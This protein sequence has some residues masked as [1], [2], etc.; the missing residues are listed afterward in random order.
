MFQKIQTLLSKLVTALCGDPGAAGLDATPFLTFLPRFLRFF[1]LSRYSPCLFLL[2]FTSSHVLRSECFRHWPEGSTTPAP[3]GAPFADCGLHA[4]RALNIAL[5]WG[6]PHG[7]CG[8]RSSELG[9]HP[10]H[11]RL[12]VQVRTVK[13][14]DPTRTPTRM[15]CV[16]STQESPGLCLFDDMV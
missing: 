12:S 5:P 4:Q 6:G 13:T 3:C 15:I 2:Y 9:A 16:P 14:W 7:K 11:I 1:I 8:R 10:P